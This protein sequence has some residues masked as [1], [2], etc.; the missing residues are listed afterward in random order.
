MHA[1]EIAVELILHHLGGKIGRVNGAQQ[2]ERESP[3][4]GPLEK[5]AG[6][7]Q[8]CDAPAQFAH[9]GL[10][11][12][13]KLSQR[14]VG[15]MALVEG[16]VGQGELAAELFQRHDRDASL[17]ETVIAGAPHGREVVDQGAGPVENEM[18]NGFQSFRGVEPGSR[19]GL[20]RG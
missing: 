19:S 11:P 12:V 9:A 15:N 2:V 16:F 3:L 4:A 17:F 14:H 5:I 6:M 1:I 13:F 20:K 10:K 18:M 7:G 8:F